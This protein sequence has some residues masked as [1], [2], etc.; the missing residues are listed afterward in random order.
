MAY[1]KLDLPIP[2]V[3]P[4]GRPVNVMFSI[5]FTS[6][7]VA[8]DFI[9]ALYLGIKNLIKG[10]P[11]IDEKLAAGERICN[12][13]I[14]Y[15]QTTREKVEE[16]LRLI[17]SCENARDLAEFVIA[18]FV[19]DMLVPEGRVNDKTFL[20]DLLKYLEKYNVNGWSVKNVQKK[21][22]DV[23]YDRSECNIS[24]RERER[25]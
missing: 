13:T 1:Y 23:A 19:I 11:A 22:V 25:R 9:T 14:I 7:E 12:K 17:D 2:M 10:L 24:R 3:S 6:E 18:H 15:G 16:A 5:P 8:R 4:L 21:L 20:E